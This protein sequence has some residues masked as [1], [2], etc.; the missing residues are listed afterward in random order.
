MLG[1]ANINIDDMAVGRDPSERS[2][3]MVI[4]SRQEVGDELLAELMA[5]DG[6]LSVDRVS[7]G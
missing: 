2:A 1:D 3:L 6:I 5:I 4:S 7:L